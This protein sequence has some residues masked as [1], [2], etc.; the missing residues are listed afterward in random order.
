MYHYSTLTVV[1]GSSI[2]GNTATSVRLP[3]FALASELV[4]GSPRDKSTLDRCERETSR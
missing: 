1:D 3:A 4:V 2:V